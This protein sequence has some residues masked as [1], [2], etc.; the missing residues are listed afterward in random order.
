M[1]LRCLFA[2]FYKMKRSPILASHIVIPIIVSATFLFYYAVSGATFDDAGKV[3]GFYQ[4]I[5]SVFPVLIG[6]FTASTM[7]QEQNAGA[8]QNLL[9]LRSKTAALFSKVVVL[10]ML[11]FFALLFTAVL[12]GYGFESVLG[13]GSYG[14]LLYIAAAF[15]MWLS[16][17][18][19]YLI[20]EILAFLFGKGV[21][22]GAGL[23]SG[24]ISALFLTNLGMY[25]WKVVPFS[26]TARMPDR[27]LEIRFG[28]FSAIQDAIGDVA[29]ISLL[30]SRVS[31][32]QGGWETNS[33]LVI[34]LIFTAISLA[35]YFA[36]AK[37]YEGSKIAD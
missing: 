10:M 14:I 28:E 29:E 11:S 26:W 22:I 32:H 24:L 30:E 31:M 6:I 2:D 21:S 23:F 5:G 19:L 25:V 9:T 16:A 12:F 27:Y 20:F 15:V 1:F 17:I 37:N 3:T 7:E 4:A 13:Q 34:Y 8:F 35:V 18:P 36:F 33:Q